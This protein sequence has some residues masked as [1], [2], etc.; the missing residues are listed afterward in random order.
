MGPDLRANRLTLAVGA[1]APRQAVAFTWQL[2]RTA[3][4]LDTLAHRRYALQA[5]SHLLVPVLRR[6][7][8]PPVRLGMPCLEEVQRTVVALGPPFV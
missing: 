6:A 2:R 8:W 1:L 5:S 7:S 4:E 3:A